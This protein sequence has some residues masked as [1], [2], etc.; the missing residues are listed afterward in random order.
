MSS[1]S[2]KHLYFIYFSLFLYFVDDCNVDTHANM[3]PVLGMVTVYGLVTFHVMC[4]DYSLV[5]S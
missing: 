2:I 5:V 3:V 1:F 4:A